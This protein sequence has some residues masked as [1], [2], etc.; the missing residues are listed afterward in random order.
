M[1]K[2]FSGILR[3]GGI[4][5]LKL[6]PGIEYEPDPVD[7]RYRRNL[8][9]LLTRFKKLYD[10]I[11]ERFGEDGL[12]LIRGVSTE[13]GVEIGERVKERYGAM[14]VKEMGM[15]IIKV[16]DNMRAEGEV[17]EFS[18]NRVVISVPKCPYPMS[19]TEICRAHITME[20]EMVKFINP[21]VEFLLEK[22]IPGG[23][24]QCLYVIRKKEEPVNKST[25][26]ECE[27]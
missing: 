27:Y 17:L 18:D 10:A 24:G 19:C 3:I 12:D 11:Y 13:Y 4:E 7:V 26:G 2:E 9:G 25:G 16:F 14:S 22:S 15:F 5:M 8:R 20:R 21:D 6:P 1:Y 23:D